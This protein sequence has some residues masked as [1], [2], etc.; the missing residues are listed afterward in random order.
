VATFADMVTVLGTGR[1]AKPKDELIRGVGLAGYQGKRAR[2]GKKI[3][4][5]VKPQ[6]LQA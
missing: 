2:K 4:G 1:S 6:R 5:F 3:D